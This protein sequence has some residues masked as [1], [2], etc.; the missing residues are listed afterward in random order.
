[1]RG[2]SHRPRGHV[3]IGKSLIGWENSFFFVWLAGAC[4]H[5]NQWKI[6]IE[7]AQRN[8]V[9]TVCTRKSGAAIK[10][11]RRISATHS[12]DINK[13]LTQTNNAPLIRNVR[14]KAPLFELDYASLYLLDTNIQK[15]DIVCDKEKLVM[16]YVKKFLTS[17]Q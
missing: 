1:M 7:P 6:I 17:F 3:Y 15:S 10:H 12:K 9:C 8:I 4:N 14:F 5:W 16:F 11:R 13:R 2:K